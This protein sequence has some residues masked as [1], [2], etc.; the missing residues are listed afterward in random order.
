MGQYEGLRFVVDEANIHVGGSIK[1]G[2]PFTYSPRVWDSLIE[3]LTQPQSQ[4][5]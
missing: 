1:E 2:D 5:S 4:S 3:E